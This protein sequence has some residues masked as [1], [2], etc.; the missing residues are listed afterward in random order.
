MTTTQTDIHEAGTRVEARYCGGTFI[1]TIL[2]YRCHTINHEAVEYH[3]VPDGPF[4]SAIGT[5][6]RDIVL[7][8]ASWTGT[9]ISFDNFEGT[10]RGIA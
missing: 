3:I 10:V 2:K 8:Y 7:V 4:E 9:P 5:L 6:D 1:G